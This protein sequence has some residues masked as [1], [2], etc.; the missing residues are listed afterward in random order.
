[1]IEDAAKRKAGM[2][3]MEWALQRCREARD[4]KQIEVNRICCA[5]K[6]GRKARSNTNPAARRRCTTAV[7]PPQ[8]LV[9]DVVVDVVVAVA[10]S[11]RRYT[12]TAMATATATMSSTFVAEFW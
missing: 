5:T 8:G 4:A 12:S 10:G 2:V 6:A 9:V 3:V 7:H 11:E 1:L